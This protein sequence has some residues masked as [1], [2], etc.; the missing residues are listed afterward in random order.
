MK[1][2]NHTE[3]RHRKIL[4]IKLSPETNSITPLLLHSSFINFALWFHS[5]PF[6]LRVFKKCS[7]FIEVDQKLLFGAIPFVREKCGRD[8]FFYTVFFLPKMT[9]YFIASTVQNANIAIGRPGYLSVYDAQLF[10]PNSSRL[11]CELK[12]LSNLEKIQ[13]GKIKS[14]WLVLAQGQMT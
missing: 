13:R 7:Y 11:Y 10:I 4:L 8:Q 9:T 14:T 5:Q 2:F 6:F 3:L 12:Y 1:V